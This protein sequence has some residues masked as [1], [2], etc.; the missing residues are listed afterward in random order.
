MVLCVVLLFYS[1]YLAET[2]VA[3]TAVITIG[4]TA[5]ETIAGKD[6]MTATVIMRSGIPVIMHEARITI[7]RKRITAV[8]ALHVK[9]QSVQMSL[10]LLNGRISGHHIKR[11]PPGKHVNKELIKGR[12]VT[13]VLFAGTKALL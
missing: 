6:R 1:C 3:Q 9:L 11:L 7:T 8:D 12:T 5:I 13:A 10:R 2:A 4:I